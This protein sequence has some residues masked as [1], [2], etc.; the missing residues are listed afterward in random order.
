MP[1]DV[2]KSAASH[3]TTMRRDDA[4]SGDIWASIYCM[5]RRFSLRN[6]DDAMPFPQRTISKMSSTFFN[7]AD[8]AGDINNTLSS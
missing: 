8:D 6:A 2:D 7:V 1:Q 4:S 3:A 5:R